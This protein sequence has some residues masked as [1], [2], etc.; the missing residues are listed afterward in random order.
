MRA[1][2][3]LV[4]GVATVPYRSNADGGERA[5]LAKIELLK[6]KQYNY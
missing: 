6:T 3:P 4:I 1:V 2:G 5:Q